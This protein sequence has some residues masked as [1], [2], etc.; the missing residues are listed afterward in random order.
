MSAKEETSRDDVA[1]IRSTNQLE[2]LATRLNSLEES[3]KSF[4]IE[5]DDVLRLDV[6]S[7]TLKTVQVEYE[8]KLSDLL[9]IIP[10]DNFAER[11]EVTNSFY[12]LCGEITVRLK[13]LLH[14]HKPPEGRP[15]TTEVAAR[16]KLPD[17]PLPIFRVW[18]YFRKKF[19]ALI[20]D[21]ESLSD[22]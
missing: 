7:D 3:V 12:E 6:F 2:V 15:G 10:S 14:T 22:Y 13:R 1:L 9:A 11:V 5:T 20:N 16:M 8:R 18:A 17:I 4:N 19:T 21:N